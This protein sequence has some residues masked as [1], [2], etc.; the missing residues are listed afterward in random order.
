MQ[1]KQ[2]RPT[3]EQVARWKRD[4]LG[5]LFDRTTRQS[6]V[7]NGTLKDFKKRLKRSASRGFKGNRRA[8]Y[9]LLALKESLRD[10]KRKMLRAPVPYPLQ[11]EKAPSSLPPEMA[12]MRTF[13]LQTTAMPIEDLPVGLK[14]KQIVIVDTPPSTSGMPISVIA[15]QICMYFPAEDTV[16]QSLG[17]YDC[18]FALPF[19]F[20]PG[21]AIAVHGI[22][23]SNGVASHI[24][25]A[26]LSN[27]DEEKEKS[28][29]RRAPREQTT[30]RYGE[31]MRLRKDGRKPVV[32]NYV[33]ENGLSP[34]FTSKMRDKLKY[35]NPY[36]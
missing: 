23:G 10:V 3:M 6:R 34:S 9:F 36:K 32:H 22:L 33:D 31:T 4:E 26:V 20:E 18:P 7:L 19:Y 15:S 2:R 14:G 30:N 21:D 27:E 16:V 8:D 29:P 17:R 11:K 24:L 35:N 13:S 1:S 28:P 5:M 25:D 12:I